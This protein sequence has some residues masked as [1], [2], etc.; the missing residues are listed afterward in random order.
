MALRFVLFACAILVATPGSAGAFSISFDWSGL[1]LCNTGR[2]NRVGSPAFRVTGL[3]PGTKSVVFKLV[4][5]DVPRYNHG[6]GTVTMTRSGTVPPGAFR[7]QSPCPPG[8]RHT[9]EWRA[10]A[11]AGP[12][13]RGAT[14][15]T[16]SA[17]RRYP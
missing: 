12:N 15:G 6:G 11:K 1:K 10:T 17:R 5:L 8:G 2:P 9:Y 7:Y 13:G 3:P 16:T 14:L 4:D